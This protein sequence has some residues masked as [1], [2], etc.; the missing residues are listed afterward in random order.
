MGAKYVPSTKDLRASLRFHKGQRAAAQAKKDL[1]L[2]AH[3]KP[4][5]K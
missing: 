4:K 1:V 2:K 3:A 5:G